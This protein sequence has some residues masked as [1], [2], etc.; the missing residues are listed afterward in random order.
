MSKV[1]RPA[2]VQDVRPH[3]RAA[4]LGRL[5]LGPSTRLT[6]AR[7]LGLSHSA[8]SNVAA[9]LLA[10]GVLVERAPRDPTTRIG[11]PSSEL[12]ISARS[13]L[14]LAVEL[15]AGVVQLAL[16]DLLGAVVRSETLEFADSARPA[17]VLAAVGAR[18]RS[19][20]E[21]AAPVPVL[22]VGVGAPGPVDHAR[23]GIRRAVNLGWTD[24]P[25]SDPLERLLECPVVVEQDAR[26]MALA[27]V[28]AGAHRGV[29]SLA[30]V[31]VEGAGV[32][33]GLVIGG[34]PYRGGIDAVAALGHIP[35]V[36]GG[37]ACSCGN[38]GCLQ[39]VASADAVAREVRAAVATPAG[40]ALAAALAEDDDPLGAL[41][42]C[43]REGDR[44]AGRIRTRFL[45][46]LARGIVVVVDLLNV[47]LV[48]VGGYLAE[49][50]A[51]E[52]LLPSLRAEVADGVFPL[53]RP[54]VRIEPASFGAQAGLAGAATVALDAF[55]YD[56]EPNKRRSEAG[57]PALPV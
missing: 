34:E 49:P 3:N 35:V 48:V 57:A 20:A 21:A 9:E 2:S 33:A 24:V 28:R 40:S 53:L 15:G 5:R 27:E 12:A 54:S 22:G 25:V 55:F 13:R 17:E 45:R 42:R 32:G 4:M 10:D 50:L 36:V 7:E 47:E 41:L 6:L 14:V 23:R 37:P 30:F 29:D 51:V 38:R 8:I 26:A 44:A 52:L 18:C 43:A 1:S 11:R 39:A 46:H 56:L 16:C 19:L 31:T